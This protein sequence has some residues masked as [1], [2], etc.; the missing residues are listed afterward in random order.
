MSKVMLKTNP[1]PPKADKKDPE[2]GE[3]TED[4]K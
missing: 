1:P 4:A 3:Q 2:T